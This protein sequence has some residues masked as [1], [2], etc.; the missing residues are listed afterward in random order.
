MTSER[1]QRAARQAGEV[2][3]SPL[4]T[5]A[6]ALGAAGIAL[7]VTG[8]AAAARLGLLLERAFQARELAGLGTLALQTFARVALPV[9]IAAWLGALA[10]GL[11]QTRGL[12]T[13]GALG[14]RRRERGTA[15]RWA[16]AAALMILAI[17]AV[18]DVLSA[19]GRAAAPRTAAQA[20]RDALGRLG[21]R[22]LLLVF[23]AGLG[24]WAWR[25]LRLER[26]LE[27]TR[28][29][30]ARERREDE[31]DPQVKAEAR[32]RLRDG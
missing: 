32:R 1:R 29:E 24:D 14:R 3:V 27:Q 11:V 30:R 9:L 13:L 23:A 31:G 20:V 17:G 2:A 15:L 5:W 25:R 18:H 4:L 6:G 7:V 28:A 16:L 21:P 26:S 19:L 8:P 12:V 10:V 22:A